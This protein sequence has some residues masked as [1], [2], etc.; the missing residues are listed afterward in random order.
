[1]IPTACL[2]PEKQ[3]IRDLACRM[4]RRTLRVQFCLRTVCLLPIRCSPP[5]TR[6]TG[7][8]NR[9]SVPLRVETFQHFITIASACNRFFRKQC[10]VPQTITSEPIHGWPGKGQRSS[11]V[12]TE[13]LYWQEHVEREVRHQALACS[14]SR[15]P[16]TPPT[17]FWKKIRFAIQLYATADPAID[18]TIKYLDFTSWY[19]FVN[20]TFPYP[21][22]HPTIITQPQTTDLTGYFGLFQSTILPSYELYHPVLPYKTQGKLLFPLCRSCAD[23]ERLKP[24]LEL[25]HHC[26]H[27]PCK[28]TFTGT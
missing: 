18:E 15:S 22:G 17:R 11:L 1:M 5:Q 3:R 27:S 6:L 7:I 4:H 21:V 20:K 25:S 28:R 26:S 16:M 23:S 14:F 8:S 9:V 13:W 10:L 12:A 19:P 2:R 24:L